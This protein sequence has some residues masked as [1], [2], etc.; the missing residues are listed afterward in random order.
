MNIVFGILSILCG[1][2]SF[3]PG[4]PPVIP[5]LGIAFASAGLVR[6]NRGSKRKGVVILC[7][8]ALALSAVGTIL[9][10]LRR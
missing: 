8:L 3:G 1:Y 7:A 9:L 6:E 10:F 5:V 4:N 2:L